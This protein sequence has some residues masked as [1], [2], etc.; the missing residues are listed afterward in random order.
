M[1]YSKIMVIRERFDV[2]AQNSFVRPS[3]FGRFCASRLSINQ[4][5]QSVN[6]SIIGFY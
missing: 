3:V 2:R 6:K 5:L 1:I 4:S